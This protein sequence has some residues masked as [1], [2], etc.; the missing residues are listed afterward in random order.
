M[1]LK[2][3]ESLEA[4][5]KEA[6]MIANR[7]REIFN[8]VYPKSVKANRGEYG[9]VLGVTVGILREN[10]FEKYNSEMIEF[11]RYVAFLL[12]ELELAQ[13]YINLAAVKGEPLDGSNRDPVDLRGLS[14]ILKRDK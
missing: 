3:K 7:I 5:K 6:E 14:D 10:G 8:D 12:K 11:K 13:L 9:E 1:G 4:K 2:M